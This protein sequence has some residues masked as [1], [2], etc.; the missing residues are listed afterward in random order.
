MEEEKNSNEGEE[1]ETLPDTRH[2]PHPHASKR[3]LVGIGSVVL[4]TAGVVIWIFW[5]EEIKEVCTGSNGACTVEIP[6][7]PLEAQQQNN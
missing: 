5:G 3:L 7:S 4:I 6:V 1:V 2:G